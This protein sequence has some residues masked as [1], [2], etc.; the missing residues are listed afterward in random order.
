MSENNESDS[1]KERKFF[2]DELAFVSFIVPVLLVSLTIGTIVW[3]VL[4]MTTSPE[5]T[6]SQE[7]C[8]GS[9]LIVNT[10]VAIPVVAFSYPFFEMV[11]SSVCALVNS[12]SNFKNIPSFTESPKLNVFVDYVW[13]QDPQIRLWRCYL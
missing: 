11:Y 5:M 3:A 9:W 12:I 1:L 7:S 10:M 8:F 13:I 2:A 6:R 4:A